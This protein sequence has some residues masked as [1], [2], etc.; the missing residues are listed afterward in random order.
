MVD[1]QISLASV[2][3]SGCRTTAKTL[4]PQ[5]ANLRQGIDQTSWVS[6]CN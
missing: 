6:A 4:S 2:D 1:K 3:D 5:E